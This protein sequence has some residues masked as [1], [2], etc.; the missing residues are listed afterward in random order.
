MGL[1]RTTH[2]SA[3]MLLKLRQDT[4]IILECPLRL[5]PERSGRERRAKKGNVKDMSYKSDI[6]IAQETTMQHITEVAKTAGVD[7]K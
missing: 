6:E 3:A 5:G 2:F 4:F 7:A 1:R